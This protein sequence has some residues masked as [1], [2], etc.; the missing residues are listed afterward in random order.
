MWHDVR[1]GYAILKCSSFY[2]LLFGR[3]SC[4]GKHDLIVRSAGAHALKSVINLRHGKGLSA[5]RARS[6]PP[7]EHSMTIV[8]PGGAVTFSLRDENILLTEIGPAP[9]R[10]SATRHTF[11]QPGDKLETNGAAPSQSA[12]DSIEQPGSQW[13]IASRA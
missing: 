13:S 7:N 4:L 12:D 3:D 9:P 1:R 5:Q 11:C 6:F 2:S 10:T 8:S